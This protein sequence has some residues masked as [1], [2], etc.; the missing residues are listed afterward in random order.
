MAL[1]RQ[2]Q[3]LRVLAVLEARSC[4][5]VVRKRDATA[6]PQVALLA[7]TSL[8]AAPPLPRPSALLVARGFTRLL[9]CRPAALPAPPVAALDN[10]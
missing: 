5:T 6:A 2:P 7:N 9:E 10:I 1:A 4:P 8:G 3:L